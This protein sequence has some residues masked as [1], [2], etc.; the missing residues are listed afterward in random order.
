[1]TIG[2]L[3]F[4][5]HL[6]VVLEPVVALVHDLV[7]GEG[8]GGLVGVGLVVGRQRLGDL[9]SH[10]SSCAA[11][12]A[13]SA[14][15]EP[16]TPALHCSITSLGLLMMNS[17]EP[18]MGSGRFAGRGAAWTWCLREFF[19]FM[20]REASQ[21]ARRGQRGGSVRTLRAPAP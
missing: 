9:G 3:Y 20:K 10:S 1:M 8:R 7:D 5:H 13:L 4:T 19:G 6:H 16:T 21:K 15:M 14:G 18:M 17:G 12:R 11:G 2:T